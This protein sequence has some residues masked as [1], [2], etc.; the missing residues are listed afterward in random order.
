MAWLGMVWLDSAAYS[1]TL[2]SPS[3]MDMVLC[4]Y[5]AAQPKS[6]RIT[7]KKPLQY[8]CAKA[9]PQYSP[10]EKVL[11]HSKYCTHYNICCALVAS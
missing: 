7:G 6:K 8:C 5:S 11:Q 2:C 9:C 10:A 1:E 4:N 3:V